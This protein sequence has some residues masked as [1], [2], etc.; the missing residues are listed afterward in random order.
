MND[1]HR[2][3]CITFW[4]EPTFPEGQCDYLV[5]GEEIC[6]DTGKLHWQSYAEF[7]N[8]VTQSTVKT[9]FKDNKCHV[10]PRWG[11]QADAIKYC[12]KDGKWKEFG[13]KKKQGERTDLEDVAQRLLDGESLR[14]VAEE[15]PTLYCKYRNGLKDLSGWGQ[16]D[17]AKEFRQVCTEVLWGDA[18][19]GKTR[20]AVEDGDD[21]FILDMSAND[22]VWFDGYNGQKTLII[23]D[24]YGWI[25]YGYLLRLLDG[26]QLRLPV[27]GSFTFARWDKVFITSNKPPK[28][29]YCGMGLTPAL[30][31]RLSKITQ[32]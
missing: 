5:Y 19:T 20:T 25:K 26:Y 16:Q 13:G 11:P 1:R 21:Y 31:R 32:K 18:G 24:F 14:T 22:S 17:A 2:N 12:K 28:D 9:R 6:P 15:N 3:Y 4:E 7:K 8:G 10:E 23:D 30:A 29:W 27:K